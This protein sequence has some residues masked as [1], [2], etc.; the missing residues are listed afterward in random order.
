MI[1]KTAIRR[2]RHRNRITLRHGGTTAMKKAFCFLF[3]FLFPAMLLLTPPP[4]AAGEEAYALH[5]YLCV[6]PYAAGPADVAVLA[7]TEDP[8]RSALTEADIAAEILFFPFDAAAGLYASGGAPAGEKAE[9]LTLSDDRTVYTVRLSEPGKYT[10]SGTPYYVLDPEIPALSALRAELDQAADQSFGDTEKATAGK[11]HDWLCARVSSVIPEDRPDLASACADPMNALLSGCAGR[12]AYAELYRILLSAAGIRSLV[13]SGETGGEAATWNLCSL[14]GAWSWTDCA[15][16]DVKDRKQKKALQLDDQKIAKDHTLSAADRAF[17]DSLTH[18]SAVSRLLDGTLPFTLTRQEGDSDRRF[19]LVCYDGP[20]FVIGDSATVTWHTVSNYDSLAS[21]DPARHVALN[22]YYSAWLE[23]EQY[24]CSELDSANPNAPKISDDRSEILTVDAVADDLS[25]FTVTFHKPGRYA[26]YNETAFYLISPEETSLVA[27]TEEIAKAVQSAQGKTEKETGKKL[28]SWLCGKVSYDYGYG[29]SERAMAADYEP[30]AALLYRKTVCGGY[31]CTYQLLLHQAGIACFPISGNGHTWCLTRF[32]GEW[33]HTDPTWS[34]PGTRYFALTPEKIKK[35]HDPYQTWLLDNLFFSDP[36]TVW[37]NQFD[38]AYQP[39]DYIP[40]ALK[41]LPASA[42]GY[43]FPAKTPGF[44]RIKNARLD[45]DLIVFDLD[46]QAYYASIREIL[47]NGEESQT[48]RY[49]A[50][51]S[52]RVTAPKNVGRLMKVQAASC[53]EY[54]PLK[55]PSVFTIAYYRGL[56]YQTTTYEYRVPM[57]KNEIRG[58]SEK[59]WR[60]FA[61]DENMKPAWTAWHLEKASAS[62]VITVYF[63]PEGAVDHAAVE[64]TPAEGSALLWETSAGGTLLSWNSKDVTDPSQ[65]DPALW[66]AISF[67]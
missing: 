7:A 47:A 44:I 33:S 37:A 63:T 20:A 43:G 54:S 53:D 48:F 58:Y 31:A 66:E 32:D 2:S 60:V 30:M 41:T 10:L 25:S 15:V 59:S 22:L 56:E 51:K 24:Y 26:F 18:G 46:R 19:E 5:A 35:D 9:I 4:A 57:K 67:N 14:D 50:S 17:T 11:L 40:L 29:E 42:D 12:E 27:L 55:N 52:S 21:P 6:K 8:G 16:D 13:V 45:K 23:D 49:G 64:Y 62:A 65:V 61:Y 3:L 34:D 1:E 36:F 39:A 28:L 38:T